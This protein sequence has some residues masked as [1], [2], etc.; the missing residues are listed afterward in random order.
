MIDTLLTL[1]GTKK[2]ILLKLV[3]GLI[4]GRIPRCQKCFGGHLR[5]DKSSGA[6]T[7]PG[8]HDDTGIV[9]CGK[10]YE[11]TEIVRMPWII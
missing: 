8:F 5:F 2:D 11:F 10:K 4:L 3:D 9:H 1:I 6:Y 7:C